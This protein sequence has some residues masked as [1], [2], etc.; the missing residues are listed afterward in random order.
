M[1]PAGHHHGEG[2]GGERKSNLTLPSFVWVGGEIAKWPNAAEGETVVAF[3]CL[4][5]I[6]DPPQK[7]KLFFV[8]SVRY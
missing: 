3:L 4:F 5:G 1:V 6:S 2:G 8:E 7:E